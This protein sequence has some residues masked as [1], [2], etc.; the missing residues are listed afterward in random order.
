MI[1]TEPKA[2]LV[3][4]LPK[5]SA[6]DILKSEGWYHIPVDTAPKRWPPKVMAFYQGEVF[7]PLPDLPPKAGKGN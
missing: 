6:L 2:V 7:D 1:Y 3:A 5:N 4:L